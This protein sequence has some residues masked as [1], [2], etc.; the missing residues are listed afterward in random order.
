MNIPYGIGGVSTLDG[1][2]VS[3]RLVI[4]DYSRLGSEFVILSRSFK[5]L[6]KKEDFKMELEKIKNQQ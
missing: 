4:Q 5:K 6:V 3:G 1:G 2:A